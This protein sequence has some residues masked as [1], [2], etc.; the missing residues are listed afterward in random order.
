M[1]EIFLASSFTPSDLPETLTGVSCDSRQIAA[2]DIFVALAGM[3]TD[4]SRYI[5]EAI[6][7][8]CGAVLLPAD[9]PVPPDLPANIPLLRSDHPRR[10]LA[11][12]AS[13]FYP[14]APSTIAAVT[15]TNG[16]SS[17]V[18]FV[19][20]LWELS[21]FQAASLGT[22]G[23][24]TSVA[25]P[26][27]ENSDSGLT[28]PDPVALHKT[29]SELDRQDVRFLALE[30]S[31]HGLDQH[32][33]DGLSLC[34]AAFTNLSHDHL[35][36]HGTQAA[37][38]AAKFRLFK[39][40]L[41]EG[42]TAVVNANAPEAEQLHAIAV[43][44]NLIYLDCGLGKGRVNARRVVPYETGSAVELLID[45]EKY[46]ATLPLIGDFQIE[47]VLIAAGLAMATGM[48]ASTISNWLSFL[49]PVKGRL[50]LIGSTPE[51][52][53]VYVDY[54]HTPDALARVLGDIK[55]HR[56]G[57]LSVVFGCG[58]ERDTG[59][60]ARMGAIASELADQVVVTDDNPRHEDPASIRKEILA[61]A[62]LAKEIADRESA[63][64][65]AIRDLPAG[66]TLVVAGKGHEQGQI[67]GGEIVLFDDAAHIRAH[68]GDNLTPAGSGP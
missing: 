53:Q 22:L 58:G 25:R 9:A 60:R 66:G 11:R 37:Y 39:E 28:S 6:K 45:G 61:S 13:I 40:L 12:L 64:E 29:L 26:K 51:G 62:P 41:P 47:N 44:R 15:G 55:T 3:K 50:E 27:P 17:V 5:Q 10:A 59:K 34:A 68:M 46:E 2:G 16:K 30:A 65:Q 8:G 32:R 31:S 7:K 4:G 63:I 56:K 35:D 36:Y 18:S 52:G 23:L 19:R 42:A 21:G 48:P 38:Q 54:A 43:A 20:Q 57:V 24:E 33:L 1:K 14:R 67:R 49:R